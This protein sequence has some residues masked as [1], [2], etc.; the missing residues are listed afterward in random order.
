MAKVKSANTQRYYREWF[1]NFA[2]F[3]D[4]GVR[5]LSRSELAIYLILMRDTQPD[6]IA[7]AGLTDLATRGGMSRRSASRAVQ[8]LIKQ[9]VLRVIRHGV[10]GRPADYTIFPP[11]TFKLLNPAT[12][13]WLEGE[14]PGQTSDG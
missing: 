6:G 5:T 8:A 2:A 4:Q 1:V 11:A 7:R 9:G 13:R 12:A 14:G 10:P 3:V